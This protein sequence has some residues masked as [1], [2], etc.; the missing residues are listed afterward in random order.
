MIR[1]RAAAERGHVQHGWLDARHTFSFASYRD[2]AHMGYRTLRVIND[3]RVAP[4][5]GFGTHGHQDMEILTWVLE[6]Q[7]AHEDSMGNGSVLGPGDAQRMSAGTGIRHSE[8]N[9]SES[10]GLRLLQIWILPEGNGIE[11]G[12]EERHFAVEERRGQLRLIAAREPTDEALRIRQ[13]VRVFASNLEDGDPTLRHELEP[14]RA[15]WIQ[16][17]KGSL[18]VN[19]SELEE[20]D[21]LVVEDEPEVVLE[22]G[23]GAEVLLFD[24][25][26]EG[27]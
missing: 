2:P 20:G 15:A 4:G 10:E 25:G 9:G 24:L 19:G 12:W 18:T 8:F 27:S 6:G 26:R 3:D 11:P 5:T 1:K 17:A 13:D 21:G 23:R 14:G 22:N 7:L 16:V